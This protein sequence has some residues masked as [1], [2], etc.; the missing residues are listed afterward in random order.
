[1]PTANRVANFESIPSVDQA[2]L[3]EILISA[4]DYP[5]GSARLP[6]LHP[7]CGDEVALRKRV[8]ALLAAAEREASFLDVGLG[9][10]RGNNETRVDANPRTSFVGNTT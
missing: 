5:T 8:E 6:P 4:F 9:G 10:V 1:M 2:R 3:M 7:A